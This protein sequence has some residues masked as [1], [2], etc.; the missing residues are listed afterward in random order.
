MA[1]L[2]TS[3]L[4]DGSAHYQAWLL[5]SSLGRTMVRIMITSGHIR[6]DRNEMAD[7]TKPI[8]F[9]QYDDDP[10]VLGTISENTSTSSVVIAE[11]IPNQVLPNRIV[12]CRP[13][14]GAQGVGDGVQRKNRSQRPVRIRFEFKELL[15]RP[16]PLLLPHCDVRERCRHQ[17]R[18]QKR[19]KERHTKRP[20]HINYKQIHIG[21][22]LIRTNIAQFSTFLPKC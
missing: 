1:S 15:R 14:R 10:M 11:M 3:R 21:F 4:R 16:V 20:Q 7:V 17:H 13:P 22:Q 18:F 9:F 6:T 12:A 8:R 2:K 5:S 19:A